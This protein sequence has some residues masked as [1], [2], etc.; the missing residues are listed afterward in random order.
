VP[1]SPD[2]SLPATLS[3]VPSNF[4]AS[5]GEPSN[6]W[7]AG[8][9][10]R[11]QM[12]LDAAPGIAQGRFVEVGCGLGLYLKRIAALTNHAVGLEF[13]PGRAKEAAVNSRPASV[14]IAANEAL[15]FPSR[16]FDVLLTNEVIEHVADDAVSA[17]ELVRIVRPGGRIVLFCPNR[18]YPVEQHGIYWKGVYHFGNI[19]L[20]NY[21]PDPL[22]N[23]LAPHVRT[24]SL[25]R[26]R[27]LFATLPVREV[28]CR[29]I[30]GG[31]DNIVARFGL[32]GR[33][34]R[35]V[36][37]SAEGTPLDALGLS[38]MLVLERVGDS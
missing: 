4:A 19:P 2:S 22:R 37:Q 20:V 27:E 35:R 28:S 12:I 21:L 23:R 5:H 30:F 25:R 3:K 29:R 32:S 24:Y 7:R 6:V 38:H 16:T 17:Q 18:W 1:Q 11:L 9:Q 36:L 14:V 15:P 8:Q 33:I 10:R 26:L 13:E 31:Y 34:L